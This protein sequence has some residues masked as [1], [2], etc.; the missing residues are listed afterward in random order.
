[1]AVVIGMV[2]EVGEI[3]EELVQA[4]TAIDHYNQHRAT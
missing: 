1:V 2:V 3:V 4:A